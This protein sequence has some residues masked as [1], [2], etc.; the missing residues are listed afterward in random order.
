M[1]ALV[2]FIK[3]ICTL[4]IVIILVSC[5]FVSHREGLEGSDKIYNLKVNNRQELLMENG[6]MAIADSFLIIVP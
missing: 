3:T 2:C 4:I 1:K 6:R 5:N